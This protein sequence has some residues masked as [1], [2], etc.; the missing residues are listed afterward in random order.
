M[1]SYKKVLF[2]ISFILCISMCFPA[3]VLA[4]TGWSHHLDTMDYCLRVHDVSLNLSELEGKSQ[5]EKESLV[6]D[7]SDYEFYEWIRYKIIKGNEASEYE[8]DFGGVDWN[9]EGEY[10]ITVTL[11]ARSSGEDDSS[12]SYTL[13]LIDDLPDYY[14]VTVNYVDAENGE[15]LQ[16][17]YI[18]E[19]LEEG[20]DYDVTEAASLIIDGYEIKTVEG[21][22]TGTVS[23]DIEIYVNYAE[24]V[25]PTHR[26][27]VYYTDAVS[28]DPL[29][30]PYVLE[31]L[32][33][34][35]TYDVTEAASLPI[36][37]YDIDAVEGDLTGIVTE[38][39]EINVKYLLTPV[40]TYVVTVRYI[41]AKSRK[42]I[43]DSAYVTDAMEAGESYD[44]SQAV[45]IEIEGYKFKKA[46]G[47]VSGIIS[48]DIEILAL[49]EKEKEKGNGKTDPKDT[50]PKKDEG[51]TGGKTG[52]DDSDPVKKPEQRSPSSGDQTKH[53]SSSGDQTK[54]TSSSSDDQK[55]RTSSS[56]ARQNTENRQVR[57]NIDQDGRGIA[58]KAEEAPVKETS[59]ITEDSSNPEVNSEVNAG[60][61]NKRQETE[62]DNHKEKNPIA[63]MGAGTIL[64]Q[65]AGPKRGWTLS[66]ST[67]ILV[68]SE[69]G[70]LG[71]LCALILSDLK[72]IHWINSKKR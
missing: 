28:G 10:R 12:I 32:E 60:V 52:K 59:K 64:P 11:P 40:Q 38:D 48:D 2:F 46:E 51:K 45:K 47:D 1:M 8:T 55:A 33:E 30:A 9:S 26:I 21:D 24:I 6:V 27:T 67:M 19:D 13:W 69:I 72:V 56:G 36:E 25:L 54:R 70:I 15:P 62:T 17:P 63:D 49:Y 43:T 66:V 58:K 3:P 20:D 53:T 57:D 29:H 4:A 14:S 35:G 22:L 31:D 68:T 61:K 37:G 39:L 50:P 65:A 16:E 23:E 7:S 42:P 5:E 71:L 41:D 34:G 18:L 44:V